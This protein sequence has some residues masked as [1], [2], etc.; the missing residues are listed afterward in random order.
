MLQ[1]QHQALPIIEKQ[2]YL[3]KTYSSG[4]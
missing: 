2:T 1:N 4:T 3:L